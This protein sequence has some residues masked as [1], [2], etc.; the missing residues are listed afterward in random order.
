MNIKL[1]HRTGIKGVLHRYMNM[2]IF[3]RTGT[4]GV[5]LG[6]LKVMGHRCVWYRY[7]KGAFENERVLD[8]D[9]EFGISR[10]EVTQVSAD[11]AATS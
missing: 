7:P 1:F 4:E 6:F 2:K 8:L 10:L 9:L 3:H 11:F 5:L